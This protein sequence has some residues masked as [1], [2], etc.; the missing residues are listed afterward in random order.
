[1]TAISI[2][3]EPMRPDDQAP[4]E[5]LHQRA[6]GP[7]RFARTAYRVREQSGEQGCVGFVARVGSLLVGSV[8]LTPI[9]VGPHRGFMLGPLTVEPAFEGRGIGLALLRRCETA[10][11]DAGGAM[12]LLVGDERYYARAGYA[13]VPA[14]RVHLPGPV[15]LAR[16]LVL[17]L[18]ETSLAEIGGTVQG[19]RSA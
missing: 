5:K 2:S 9:T 1:M 16:I 11:R 7:G 10:A 4:I 17:A 13:R 12:I 6:F 15:D 3:I 18:G 14:G 19:L 8:L